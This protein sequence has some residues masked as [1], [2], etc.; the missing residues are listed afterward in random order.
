M[1]EYQHLLGI[2]PALIRRRPWWSRLWH[3]IAEVFR[4]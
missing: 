2:N 3:R 4:A 1:D